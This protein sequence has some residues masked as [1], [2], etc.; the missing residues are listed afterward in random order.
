MAMSQQQ[1][2]TVFSGQCTGTLVSQSSGI[3]HRG[4]EKNKNK[5]VFGTTHGI[6]MLHGDELTP[7]LIA[8]PGV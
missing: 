1:S 2:G 4:A 8:L 5:I 7:T 6:V 3:L